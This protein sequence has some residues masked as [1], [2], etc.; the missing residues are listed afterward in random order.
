M[1]SVLFNLIICA[2]VEVRA[3]E[4]DEV[5]GVWLLY[6]YDGKLFRRYTKYAWV[7]E[8]TEPIEVDGGKI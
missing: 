1:E 4:A 5:G 7:R 8:L 6:K 3:R 2:V